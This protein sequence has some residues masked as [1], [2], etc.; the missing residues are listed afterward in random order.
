MSDLHKQTYKTYDFKSVGI[1]QKEVDQ[2]TKNKLA[3]IPVG[4]KTPMT[5]GLSNDWLL[6]MHVSLPDQLTDN[7]KNMLMTNHGERVGLYNFGANLRPLT[8]ELGT[9]EVDEE[10]MK[11]IKETTSR[12]M[13]FVQL[14][15]FSP[16]I[17]F[18]DNKEVAKVG[19]DIT[20]DMSALDV[21]NK[22]MKVTLFVAG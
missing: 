16:F 13:P 4:I 12:Y 21:Y 1:T 9:A 18:N 6:S 20:F 14:K 22:L 3:D 17:N 11:R 19:F 7:L 5:F 2:L 10:A 15:E 8:F